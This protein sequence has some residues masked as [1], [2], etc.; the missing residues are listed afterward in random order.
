MHRALKWIEGILL[1]IAA[2]LALWCATSLIEAHRANALPIPPPTRTYDGAPPVL[3]PAVA[4]AAAPVAVAV[5]TG[6]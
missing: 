4:P 2:V 5:S 3:T 6:N 1:A